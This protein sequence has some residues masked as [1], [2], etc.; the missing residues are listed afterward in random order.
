MRAAR[1]VTLLCLPILPFL[2][3]T[4][5]APPAEAL[6]PAR[7]TLAVFG[8]NLSELADYSPQWAF[9]DIFKQSRRGSNRIPARSSTTRTATRD[10]NRSSRC[11][12]SWSVS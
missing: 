4:A 11:R 6:E 12:R 10:W 3:D 8:V 5:Q 7:K 2:A 1:I 9:V